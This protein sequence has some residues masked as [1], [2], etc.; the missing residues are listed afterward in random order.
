MADAAEHD[1][2]GLHNPPE[3]YETLT[4]LKDRLLA[5]LEHEQHSPSKP[6]FKKLWKALKKLEQLPMTR[7][8]VGQPPQNDNLPLRQRLMEDLLSLFIE[9]VE[10]L[11]DP[12]LQHRSLNLPYDF[13]ADLK[14]QAEKIAGQQSEIALKMWLLLIFNST[15]E[16]GQ[17]IDEFLE[18]V[19]GVGVVRR[20]FVSGRIPAPATGT[21]IDA[22]LNEDVVRDIR[23]CFA[24]ADILQQAHEPEPSTRI[25]KSCLT[26]SMEAL[27]E[28]ATNS[29]LKRVRGAE[30]VVQSV[31]MNHVRMLMMLT[32]IALY[33][34][35]PLDALI[36]MQQ[37]MDLERMHHVDLEIPNDYM[38]YLQTVSADPS[39][40]PN[41]V[42]GLMASHGSGIRG[43][44]LIAISLHLQARALQ[45]ALR[46]GH[47]EAYEFLEV[48]L[49]CVQD[50]LNNLGDDIGELCFETC[51]HRN[52]YRLLLLR[53][54][55]RIS[56]VRMSRQDRSLPTSERLVIVTSFLR[57]VR[58]FSVDDEV[59]DEDY[60]KAFFDVLQTLSLVSREE[61][62]DSHEVVVNVCQTLI[63]TF[64]PI[65]F[66]DLFRSYLSYVHEVVAL[67]HLTKG[68][69]A[70]FM[71]HMLLSILLGNIYGSRRPE[72]CQ[73]D[74]GLRPLLEGSL[75]RLA[76]AVAQRIEVSSGYQ[77][78]QLKKIWEIIQGLY[79]VLRVEDLSR[80]ELGRFG[81]R[82]LFELS[83]T[84][85]VTR[86]VDMSASMQSL[87]TSDIIKEIVWQAYNVIIGQLLAI[88]I[89]FFQMHVGEQ[90]R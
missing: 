56:E 2:Q 64:S 30:G 38:R 72:G 27:S 48:A 9:L 14:N 71:H 63:R 78:T 20:L 18:K 26:W 35:E 61:E 36:Y 45:S 57:E 39:F 59:T 25:L 68:C 85:F 4:D 22:R 34:R 46:A 83:K 86:Y 75:Q 31:V 84:A 8:N 15:D 24:L 82:S 33:E 89:F 65:E 52:T 32:T 55:V 58:Q 1:N 28:P 62:E 54:T 66:E 74:V 81:R 6:T 7:E 77:E 50:R 90:I 21:F 10:E 5:Y 79:L 67:S 51:L 16:G 37:A 60:Q 49:D 42:R 40:K 11:D 3:G 13:M 87:F 17:L 19:G 44:Q 43:R 73:P 41:E 29:M 69:T 80:Y 88:H 23:Y 47:D 53:M 70:Q 76:E 12:W